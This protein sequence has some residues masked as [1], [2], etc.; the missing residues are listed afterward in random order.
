ML[1]TSAAFFMLAASLPAG[2]ADIPARSGVDS[3]TVFPLGAEVRRVA[4]V[5]V[6]AGAHTIVI[7]DLPAQAQAASIRVE[8]KATGRL[9]IGSVDSRALTVPSG[10]PAVAESARRRIES[11]IE[12]LR[13]ERALI[14]AE[15][16]AAEAQR[17]FLT[18][19]LQL[20]TRPAPA[21]SSTAAG[22]DWGK[23]LG[24]VAKELTPVNKAIL[25]A[26]VRVREVDR[27]ISDAQGRLKAEAP[28]MVSRTEV[29]V[30]V[31][32]AQAVDAEITVRYQVGSASWTPVYD[33]RL[34]TGSKAA[35][36]NART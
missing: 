3:V 14:V 21:T 23:V 25:E 22:E 4:K 8:G 1:R 19:L 35:A 9:E 34:A 33:V 27:R 31:A 32:A 11:E 29:K 16:Q 5:K 36:P 24:L 18:N 12:R 6:P 17:T 28:A 15:Q 20:P 2:A 7:P 30:A 26:G 10:D 13:D